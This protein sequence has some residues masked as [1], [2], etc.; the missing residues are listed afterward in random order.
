MKANW[1]ALNDSLLLRTTFASSTWMFSSIVS[2]I[3]YNWRLSFLIKAVALFQRNCL[4]WLGRKS[5]SLH[6]TS[7]LNDKNSKEVQD[8][9]A[10]NIHDFDRNFS[11]AFIIGKLRNLSI[12]WPCH[13]G[14]HCQMKHRDTLHHRKDALLSWCNGAL[15]LLTSALSPLT[16]TVTLE[17]RLTVA[18]HSNLACHE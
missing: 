6:V 1:T 8:K 10:C 18:V 15:R 9:K 7:F 3:F 17:V 4:V 13:H 12:V 5:C 14:R 16:W 2:L 11:I